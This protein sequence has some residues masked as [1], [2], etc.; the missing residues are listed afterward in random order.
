MLAF[1]NSEMKACGL[2]LALLLAAPMASA[3]IVFDG[4]LAHVHSPAGVGY[5][6]HAAH[7]AYP[8]YQVSSP[9]GYVMARSH[10]WRIYGRNTQRGASA[11]VGVPQAGA[12]NATSVREASV[13]NQVA[14]A[15]A[16]RLGGRW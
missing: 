11:L 7:L 1:L 4:R 15:Q 9:A 13:R 3:T 6:G 2:F 8:V 12:W 5:A 16:Y 14:R 10:V